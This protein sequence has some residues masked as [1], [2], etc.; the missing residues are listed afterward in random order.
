MR[1]KVIYSYVRVLGQVY[2][3]MVRHCVFRCAD[4]SCLDQSDSKQVSD[5]WEVEG[6]NFTQSS[7]IS[8][9]R[10]LLSECYVYIIFPISILN[11]FIPF[12]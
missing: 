4:R 10:I 8:G 12:L 1:A 2:V 5:K 11:S 7:L 9:H 3:S 6:E